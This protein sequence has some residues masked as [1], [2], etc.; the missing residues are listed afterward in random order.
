MSTFQPQIIRSRWKK[1]DKKC[2]CESTEAFS[3][4]LSYDKF[5]Y[6]LHKTPDHLIRHF[7]ILYSYIRESNLFI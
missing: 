6:I 7:V 5:S 1:D 4:E 2:H 3:L